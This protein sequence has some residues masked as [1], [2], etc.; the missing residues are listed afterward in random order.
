MTMESN[1]RASD[2]DVILEARDVSVHYPGRGR[3]D[4]PWQ[5]LRDVSLDIERGTTLGLVGESGSGKTTFGQ[6]VLRRLDLQAGTVRFDGADVSNLRGRE[7]KNLRKRVQMV[8]QNPVGS[9]NPRMTVLENIAEPLV[10]HGIVKKATAARDQVAELMDLVGLRRNMMMRYPSQFSGGQCQRV[11]IAR[12]LAIEPE[13]IVADEPVSSLD[14]SIQSQIVN[15]LSDLREEKRLTLLFIAHDLA[16]V[17]H[18][19]DKVATMYAG[20][21]V[22]VGKPGEMYRAPHHP[23]TQ[24]LLSAIPIPQYPRPERSHFRSVSG[25]APDLSNPPEGC[26]FASRCPFAE[27]VCHRV[28]PALEKSGEGRFS[29]CHFRDKLDLAGTGPSQ[30]IISN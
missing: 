13:F 10:A 21:I 23:Y 22:E 12:A 17:N 24:T 27:D 28:K 5:A 9:L 1:T 2:R 7:L 4:M 18:I 3:K 6:A 25:S 16:V 14:V 8:F 19:A 29:A 26:S 11:G 30:H 20:E 15:L